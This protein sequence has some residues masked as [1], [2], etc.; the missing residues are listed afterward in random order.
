M[1]PLYDCIIL[2]SVSEF[3][4]RFLYVSTCIDKTKKQP[5][6]QVVLVFQL[7]G[8]FL[9]KMILTKCWAL[10]SRNSVLVTVLLLIAIDYIV[11]IALP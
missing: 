6:L 1:N 5:I 4:T 9:M 2:I 10:T 8:A 3:L 7:Q 11:C